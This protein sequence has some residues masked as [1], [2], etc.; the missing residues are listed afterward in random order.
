LANE[1]EEIINNQLIVQDLWHEL[2]KSTK[3]HPTELSKKNTMCKL[4]NHGWAARG[5]NREDFAEY[6]RIR[7]W[8]N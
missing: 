6:R 4:H 7:K 5:G 1:I 2:W 8:K 3:P